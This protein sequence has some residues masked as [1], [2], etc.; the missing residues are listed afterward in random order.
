[1]ILARLAPRWGLD[2]SGAGGTPARTER[3]ASRPRARPQPRVVLLAL[4]AIAAG[5]AW[6]SLHYGLR[7]GALFL[8]GAACG[9]VLYHAAFGFTAVFRALVTTGDGRGIRAQMLM[10]GVATLLFAPILERGEVLGA[11]VTGA[12]A[13]VGFSVLIGAFVF[14]V[15]MQLGGGCGSGTLFHLGAGNGAM[16]ATLAG[17]I[18]GSVAATFHMPFWWA[19][20]AFRPI[21]LGE[22]LGWTI[23]VVIQL[24]ALALI[25][26]ATLVIERRRGA[27]P[28]PHL[29]SAAAPLGPSAGR[30][31]GLAARI[32]WLGVR[33]LRG[34]WPMLAGGVAL[35]VL[36]LLTLVLAGHP[37]G[38]TWA[39]ALWGAK[40][41]QLMGYDLSAVPFWTGDFQE[42]ALAESVLADVTSIMD[43]GIVLG[44]LAAAGLAGR[45][46]PFRR[47][48]VR[49]VA[50]GI[51][52]GLLLGYGARIAFGCNIGAYFSGIASTSLHGWLWGAA[53]LLGT[54]VGVRLRVLLR[55]VQ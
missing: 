32:A 19:V 53:A 43:F 18:V 5:A 40:L 50:S 13:P 44:A 23:A 54:P 27:M 45:F 15:G 38:I 33:I 46:A 7:Q 37:W 4:A 22:S 42:A 48:P 51:L 30:G 31:P 11:P 29:R 9:G 26:L 47:V 21:A 35:A 28:P 34:P 16:V 3:P 24:G 12:V 8:V 20:P 41:L 14:A 2:R 36:N 6:L 17:F 49:V 25:A 39:F 1:M 10:L 55:G 52:G